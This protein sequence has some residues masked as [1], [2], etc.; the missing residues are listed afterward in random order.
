MVKALLDRSDLT[1]ENQETVAVCLNSAIKEQTN[2][3]GNL[4]T[5]NKCFTIED[6]KKGQ[7]AEYWVSRV[8]E[9]LKKPARLSPRH[10]RR[11][12]KEV[13]QLLWQE[14]KL[15]ISDDDALFRA[16]KE[17][18]QVVLSHT[19]KEEV[20]TYRTLQVIRV[21]FYWPKMAEEVRHFINHQR[22]RVRQ[23]K[24]HIQGK[25]PLLPTAAS[26]P[27]EIVRIDFLHLEMPSG[28][29]EYI[30]LITDHFTRYI[31]VYPTRNK[32]AK[33]AATHLFLALVFHLSYCMIKDGNLRMLFSNTLQAC[34]VFKIFEALLTTQKQMA[35]LN[36]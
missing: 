23:K 35:S 34:W 28:G 22:P 6:I 31:E 18:H 33:T 20:D 3:L 12:S 32:T 30:L 21:R 11:E 27:L 7:R 36:G 15:F 2:I 29:F 10:G 25:A 8:K 17:Q 14:V 24:P 5:A 4:T 1:Q 13:Q 9:I 16:N 26:A 19:L